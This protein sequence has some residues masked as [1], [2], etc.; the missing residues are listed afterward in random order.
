MC[1][2]SSPVIV[3]MDW[4]LPAFAEKEKSIR[5]SR[6]LPAFGSFNVKRIAEMSKS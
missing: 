3:L 1:L 6:A 4:N 2:K 5:A